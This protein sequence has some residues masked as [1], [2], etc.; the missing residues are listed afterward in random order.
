[1][2]VATLLMS[3]VEMFQPHP[4][5]KRRTRHA[6][7]AADESSP[8]ASLQFTLDQVDEA[9]QQR[10]EVSSSSLADKTTTTTSLVEA[11]KPTQEKLANVAIVTLGS[12]AVTSGIGNL[13]L[14]Y[15]WFQTWR[16]FWP[17]VGGLYVVD[18]LL[19]DDAALLPFS[20]PNNNKSIKV[21]SAILGVGL[22]IG[23]AYDAFMPVW[24]TGPNVITQAGI[25]QDSAAA[26]LLLSVGS[27]FAGDDTERDSSNTN[28]LL[29]MLLLG[30]LYTLADGSIDELVG[31]VSDALSL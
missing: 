8:E 13:L 1:M 23:G 11:V 9:L 19:V 10:S 17:L 5:T 15:D 7:T 12:Y 30:Q 27:I 14:D 4:A 24:Q 22:L 29:Q 26:L 28:Q 16:Y 6:A 20:L 21:V 31:R 25:G 3:S 2:I 18:G